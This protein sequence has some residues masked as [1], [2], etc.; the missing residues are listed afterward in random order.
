MRKILRT[1]TRFAKITSRPLFLASTLQFNT[2]FNAHSLL[3]KPINLFSGGSA[4]A[5]KNV[6]R[7][8]FEGSG[9]YV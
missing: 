5:H 4:Q 1:T 2:N 7:S 6:S 8:S 9:F 3:N